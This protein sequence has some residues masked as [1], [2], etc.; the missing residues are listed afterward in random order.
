VAKLNIEEGLSIWK[1]VKKK[2]KADRLLEYE[3]AYK[4]GRISKEL[5]EIKRKSIQS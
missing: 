3:R 2:E 1:A 4:E 5:L